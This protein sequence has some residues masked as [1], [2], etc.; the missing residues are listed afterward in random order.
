MLQGIPNKHISKQVTLMEAASS[1]FSL[2]MTLIAAD[3]PRLLSTLHTILTM[4][5]MNYLGIY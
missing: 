3:T 4:N 2:N 5:S 1:C